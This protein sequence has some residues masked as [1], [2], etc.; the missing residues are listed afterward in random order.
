MLLTAVATASYE[1]FVYIYKGAILSSNIEMF[2]FFKILL[3]EIIY[4]TLITIIIYPIMQKL[5]I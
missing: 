2:I 5:R 4:N 3:I 1:I